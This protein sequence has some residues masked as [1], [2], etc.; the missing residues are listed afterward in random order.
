MGV[1]SFHQYSF[2]KEVFL[3]TDHTPLVAMV[4]KDMATFSQ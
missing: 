2:S 4:S 1:S 3:T